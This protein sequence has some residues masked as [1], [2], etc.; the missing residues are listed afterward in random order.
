MTAS[1]IVLALCFGSPAGY[2][3]TVEDTITVREWLTVGP[4]SVG[5]RE[6][7]IDPLADQGGEEAIR[8]YEGMEHPSIM[9]QGGVVRWRKVESED[10]AL[11]VWYE[12]VDVDWDALQAHH[13]WAGRRGVAYAYAELEVRGRRRTLILTDKVGAF[14]LN[15]RM[16]YGDVYGY[17][18]GKVRTFVPVVLRDGTNRILLKFGV[19]GGVWEKERKIIFKI[20]PVHE[21]LVFNISDVTVPDAVR[22]EVIE[23]WMAIPLINATEV[24]LRK[25]RLRVGGDEVFR[26]TETVVGFMPPL[27]IQKVPVRVKTRGAVTTEK[28][29]L[30]LPVVAEVDGRK[31]SSVVPVRVRNLEEGFRTTYVSSVDSSVQEF[32]VLPPKDFHPEGTYGLILALHG[33]SVPSG[34]VLGCY[35]PK[36]WAFV[37]GPTNRRPYGFD[38]QDWGRI[39]PL[40]VLDE[41]KRR[42][43][44]D[45][46]RVYLTGHSMGGHG[47]WHVG[48]HHPDLFA[49]IAPSAGWTSFN[50]YVPFFMRKSYIYAHP[51]LRSIRDMV[52]REDRAEVFVENALN[53][54]VFVLHGGKDEEVPP[55]HARMMVKR[56]KQLGYEVTYREVPGKKH[57]WDLKG[58]PGT[59]CVNYPEMMEFL[60]SKVRD[61]AP[62]KVVFKTTDLALNDGIYWVRIDQMEELYRDALIVA[63]VKGD[64]VID[65]KVSNVAGFT[66]FPPERWVGL[67]RL[68]ILVNGHELRV[69]LKKYGPVSI[70]RDKKGRF[71]L[72]RIKHKG[73]WKRPGLYGP[74]KRA[75]FSPFVFVYG[76]I[77][78]PEETEVNLHLARTKAQKWWYRGNGWVRIV[79]DTSVDERIIENYNLILFGGPESNL[80]T[81]RINDELPIRIEGG[82]IVLGERTVPGEHLALKEVY[83][84]PL[85]PER[86]VL[87]N[88][89]TDLEGT[90]LTG[91]LD[92][93]YASSGLPD[94]IVYGKAIR[95]EGWG[96]VVAAGFFDVEWKLA[97]SL[98]FFGP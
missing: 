61:G 4:F 23:G 24:P 65:V 89:G 29:T 90:K 26:R 50:I 30:F 12:D 5:T 75:Y 91:A 84:N 92:A 41:M 48:L 82:R 17:R 88:A 36:P 85:N 59:A 3:P 58:V 38:W 6:G 52:I 10:G 39:D 46:D 15:G 68:R 94:Y 7:Y 31:V 40:E 34:W 11:R 55:I 20:L 79:P 63:E 81:R 60:R 51:K 56:L 87:V 35:D 14:W 43:R 27:T 32:S 16:Y 71:A 76:T 66:L 74:I 78:T 70:R 49:A 93:L 96:G 44:I 73:L 42:Y 9:A 80:V 72:G 13:G 28:D 69:D 86:L 77:G 22:G 54:P 2:L 21:P 33:A 57:W 47:T 64:H 18:R 37:V 62:K 95:T 25:V 8:P 45:P 1:F 67:G 98:G 83:P 19:W 53:L 97:P